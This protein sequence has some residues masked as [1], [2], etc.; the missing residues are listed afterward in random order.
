M[1]QPLSSAQKQ[2]WQEKIFK[3]QESGLSIK[4]WCCNH[5]IPAHTFYYWKKRLHSTNTSALNRSS[6]SELPLAKEETGITIE[7]REFRI[8]LDKDF[9]PSIL[10]QCL[11]VLKE[12]SC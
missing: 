11:T 9:E 4:Q 3:Q 8:H 7:C 5:Q 1:A 2:E 6:F 10:K 12:L